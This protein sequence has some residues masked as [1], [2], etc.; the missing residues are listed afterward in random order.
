M[1]KFAHIVAVPMTG[2]GL[3]GGFRNDEWFKYRI[4]IFKKY[5]L[6]SLK[7]QTNKAFM[8]WLTFRPQEENH[9]LVKELTEYLEEQRIPTLMTFNGMMW[10]DDKFSKSLKASIWNIG[11]IVRQCWREKNFAPLIPNVLEAFLGRKNK[12][13]VY[14]LEKSLYEL[15]KV[16]SLLDANYVYL[17]RIDSDDMFHKDALNEIQKVQ[18]FEGALVYKNGYIYNSLT[19]QLAE[20]NPKTNPPF[21]TVIFLGSKFFNPVAHLQFYRDFKSHEDVTR[22]FKTKELK[23]GRYCVLIHGKHIS[24]TWEH[25]FKGEEKDLSNLKDFGL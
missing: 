15:R 6:Q 1:I 12:T 21:H 2:V 14:R 19:N 24:T 20:W 16:T 23:D 10:W 18:P 3:F 22:V 17:T 5:T 4:E 8:L 25:P 9:P 11:R 7:N 13:L